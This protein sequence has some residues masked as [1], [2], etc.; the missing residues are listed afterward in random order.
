M[1]SYK[2]VK[3]QISLV[4]HRAGDQLYD[5]IN[6]RIRNQFW[7]QVRFQVWSRAINQVRDQIK[8]DI[9]NEKP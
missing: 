6:S 7:D 4:R 5:Q 9:S 8:E 1:K 2:S 3:S